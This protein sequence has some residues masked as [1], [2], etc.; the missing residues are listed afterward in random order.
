VV[1]NLASVHVQD[2]SGKVGVVAVVL[3]DS[4]RA[5]SAYEESP[6]ICR[7]LLEVLSD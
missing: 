5:Q 1:Q 2:R 4:A 6:E 7:S 3:G